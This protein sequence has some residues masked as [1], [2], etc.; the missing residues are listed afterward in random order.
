MNYLTHFSST[1]M[2]WYGKN[3]RNFPWIKEKDPY[4]IWLS[5]IILQ[6]T[7]VEQGLPY[8]Q[9][10]IRQYPSVC[11]LAHAHEKEVFRLWQGLGYYNRCK[12]L[13]AT[14][15]K[16]CHQ[17]EGQFPEN[18][19]E[20]IK[21]PGIGE[22]TAAALASFAFGL[23]HAAV[24]GNAQ[25]VLARYFGI[26]KP[27][28]SA[29][30]KKYFKALA[31][32]VLNKK[33]PASFNQAMMDFGATVCIPRQPHCQ[34]C[35]LT[36]GCK[37]FKLQKTE[38]LPLKQARRIPK[39]R[40]IHYFVICRAGRIYIQ[41]RTGK[42]IW[43]NLHEFIFYEEN[44]LLN[45][46]TWQKTTLFRS[47]TQKNRILDLEISPVFKHQLTHQT[48]YVKFMLI[49]LQKPPVLPDNNYFAITLDQLDQYAFPRVIT[50][51]LERQN[52]L[53]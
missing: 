23:P 32:R 2:K 50:L 15:K 6:Q 26:H 39:A 45:K 27:V 46:N 28:N 49:R 5:E 25:R 1:L 43:P 12:N 33:D 31:N 8:Y 24:D 35:P 29:E 40:F 3:A 16:I 4:R 20:I 48:L 34:Q 42:D 41:K 53:K 51:Y 11:D 21:L 22:Y 36:S 17:W 13:L 14:A 9:K 18:Y 38:E 37:A 10:F 7:R 30:G 52:G 47:L 44:K 19:D